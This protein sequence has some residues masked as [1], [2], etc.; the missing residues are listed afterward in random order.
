MDFDDI[1]K[2]VTQSGGE[3]VELL[4]AVRQL[5]ARA[6]RHSLVIGALKE[7]L[8]SQPGCSED[9]FAK[10]LERAVAQKAAEKNC[11][12]CGKAMSAKHNRCIYC[13]EPRPPE[14]L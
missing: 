3:L 13:G 1:E 14:L 9:L 4:A 12:K 10:C 6:D 8:L 11:R 5:Q 2:K 7:M